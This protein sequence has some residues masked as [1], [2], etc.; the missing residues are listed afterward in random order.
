LGCGSGGGGRLSG[1]VLGVGAIVPRFS[2]GGDVEILLVRRRAPPFEGYWSFPGGHVEP[3][4]PL[5]EAARRELEEETGVE[6]EPLGVVHI[7]ELVARG[8]GGAT[9]YVIVDVLMR[10]L[11]GEPRAGSDAAEARFVARSMLGSVRLTPGAAA[12]LE[13]LDALLNGCRLQPLRTV[14]L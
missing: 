6:A 7:H 12:V 13:R 8:P 4:E 3:G 11:S 14:C 5:L 10:Y 1:P 9:H 2:A